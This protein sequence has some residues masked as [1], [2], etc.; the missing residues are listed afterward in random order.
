MQSPEHDKDFRTR[1]KIVWA[2]I[3]GAVVVVGAGASAVV[4]YLLR[5]FVPRTLVEPP[6]LFPI[7]KPSDFAVGVNSEFLIQH[8]IY[9]VK[10]TSRLFVMYARCTHLGCSPDWKPAEN[11][12]RCPC[13]GSA[14][15]LGSQFDGEGRNCAGPAPRPLD[16]AHIELDRN[17]RIVVDT[18]RLY[19]WKKDGENDFNRS[20]TYID[21]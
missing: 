4:L 13:H 5:F 9:V 3:V 19:E 21:V 15:C 1:R 20:G 8:R 16:R 11:R 18:A 12:F 7:G 17:G 10:N 6:T 2:A 14:F